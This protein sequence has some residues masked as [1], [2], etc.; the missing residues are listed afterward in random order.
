MSAQ[1]SLLPSLFHCRSSKTS[2]YD[3]ES[4]ILQ[5]LSASEKSALAE[6]KTLIVLEKGTNSLK[7]LAARIWVNPEDDQGT[8]QGPCLFGTSLL[9]KGVV[10]VCKS[11]GVSAKLEKV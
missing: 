9:R 8:Y 10:A 11:L 2:D 1:A 3:D 6:L 5:E 7:R 4:D